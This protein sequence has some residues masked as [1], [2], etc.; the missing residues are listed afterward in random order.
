M[1]VWKTSVHTKAGDIFSPPEQDP[2]RLKKVFYGKIFVGNLMSYF[3]ERSYGDGV[4][5]IF[6]RE[7]SLKERYEGQLLHYGPRRKI[8]D[9]AIVE[10]YA[11]VLT[12]STEEYGKYMAELYVDRSLQFSEL[13]IKGFDVVRY[14]GDLEEFFKLNKLL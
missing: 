11:K 5:E 4:R 8:I 10:D 13:K 6:Y 14:V 1:K 9:C 2:T 7:F 3:E 12:M